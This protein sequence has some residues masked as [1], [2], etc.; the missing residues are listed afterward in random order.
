MSEPQNQTTDQHVSAL[1]DQASAKLLEL[2]VPTSPSKAV[3]LVDDD[4]AILSWETGGNVFRSSVNVETERGKSVYIL[5]Q[6]RGDFGSK[7]LCDGTPFHVA[8]YFAH[9]VERV[10]PKTGEVNKVIR[11]VLVNTE[12][13]TMSTSSP[14]VATMLAHV[15]RVYGEGPWNPPLPCVFRQLRS[16]NN[17]PDGSPKYYSTFR[18]LERE[19]DKP[20]AKGK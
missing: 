8:D 2:V 12:G 7:D 5:C 4:G 15:R 16:S 17:N 20:K 13:R 11:I 19:V 18:V 1:E 14:A 3:E 6:S 9:P 10:D